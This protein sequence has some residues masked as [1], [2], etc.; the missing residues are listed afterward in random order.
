M[1]SF[2]NCSDFNISPGVTMNRIRGHKN[3]VVNGD[4]KTEYYGPYKPHTN[5]NHYGD[6]FQD[7][8]VGR[9]SRDTW[10]YGDVQTDQAIPQSEWN[11][12]AQGGYGRHSTPADLPSSYSQFSPQ[13]QDMESPTAHNA[14]PVQS[15]ERLS[16]ANHPANEPVTSRNPFALLA[17][18]SPVT[19]PSYGLEPDYARRSLSENDWD[20]PGSSGPLAP[21]PAP[22]PASTLSFDEAY[23]PEMPGSEFDPPVHPI[24]TSDPRMEYTGSRRDLWGTQQRQGAWAE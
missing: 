3:K 23:A 7:C 21:N 16:I 4:R 17:A 1:A 10:N 5:H 14:Y 19:Q 11:D 2:S 13:V 22:L 15:Q 9:T 24:T 6:T 20:R 12:R 8:E 18:S